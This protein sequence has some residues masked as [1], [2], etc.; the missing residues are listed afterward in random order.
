M[1]TATPTARSTAPGDGS[2]GASTG[3]GDDDGPVQLV[4]DG[5]GGFWSDT[6]RFLAHIDADGTLSF[7]DKVMESNWS[8][9]FRQAHVREE[10]SQV[11]KALAGIVAFVKAWYA[12][13]NHF[14][15][16]HEAQILVDD[17][18]EPMCLPVPV[19]FSHFDPETALGLDGGDPH[20]AQKLRFAA[21]TEPVRDAL[22]FAK[23]HED[24]AQGLLELGPRLDAI[25]SDPSTP[26]A[27]RRLRLFD[28]WASCDET[29]DPTTSH[30]AAIARTQIVLFINRRLPA[31]SVD[32]YTP[33]E[34]DGLNASGASAI[35]FAPYA[36]A[37]VDAQARESPASAP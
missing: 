24:L 6:P 8:S 26:P 35:P 5:E 32:A 33:A 11:P 16:G 29:D 22:A 37:P 28:L 10:Y 13:P 9:C 1:P 23:E 15:P 12:D 36:D 17:Q 34:I 27:D 20:L 2:G 31:G 3:V 7:D 18:V 19:F 30:D 25:W 14:N 4:P 21:D